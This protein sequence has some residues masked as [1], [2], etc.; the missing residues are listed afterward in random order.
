MKY[1]ILIL[2]LL[3]TTTFGASSALNFTNLGVGGSG[4]GTVESAVIGGTTSTTNCDGSNCA[5]FNNSTNITNVSRSGTG[6]FQLTL[7]AG[8]CTSAWKCSATGWDGPNSRPIWCG[9]NAGV[10]NASTTAYYFQCRESGGTQS[11]GYFDIQ[12]SCK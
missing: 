7:T 10:G 9:K 6:Q 3:S 1:L 8:S 4:S 5:V 11:D 2:A 12:C